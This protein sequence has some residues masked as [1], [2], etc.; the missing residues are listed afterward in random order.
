MSTNS[1]IED[2]SNQK[3]MDMESRSVALFTPVVCAAAQTEICNQVLESLD[4]QMLTGVVAS[5]DATVAA[6]ERRWQQHGHSEVTKLII[7]VKQQKTAQIE[8]YLTTRDALS[9]V[10][11]E[12]LKKIMP[13]RELS[14]KCGTDSSCDH[15]GSYRE[16]QKLLRPASNGVYA[17]KSLIKDFESSTLRTEDKIIVDAL[18]QYLVDENGPSLCQS[19]R[20]VLV[21]GAGLSGLCCHIAQALT[22]TP[23]SSSIKVVIDAMDVSLPQL[24]LSAGLI[25]RPPDS[26]GESTLAAVNV[27]PDSF[28][29]GLVRDYQDHLSETDLPQNGGVAVSSR[30]LPEGAILRL[31]HLN[32]CADTLRTLPSRHAVVTRFFLDAV[33][34]VFCAVECIMERLSNLGIWINL[35]PLKYHGYHAQG[36]RPTWSQISQFASS[37]LGFEI[38]EERFLENV[39]YFLDNAKCSGSIHGETYR[40]VFSVMRKCRKPDDCAGN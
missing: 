38:L 33:P 1:R 2:L 8:G 5:A 35:G 9:S 32:F 39:P 7:A 24:V 14:T 19:T 28:T 3:S 30:C 26:G 18:K 40:C 27:F 25:G 20:T 16:L 10:F 21:P 36:P 31:W 17:V 4:E 23:D 37:V 22:A 11:E 12:G 29:T 15:C 34:D 13:I 6:L